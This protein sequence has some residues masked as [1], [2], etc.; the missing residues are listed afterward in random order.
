VYGDLLRTY[1][2]S[3]SSGKLF[4]PDMTPRGI[5]EYTLGYSKQ[6]PNGWT[7][8]FNSRYRKAGHFWEDTNNNARSRYGDTANIEGNSGEGPTDTSD[9]IPE[10]NDYRDQIGS[11]SSYVIAELDGAFTKYYEAGFDLEKRTADYYIKGSYTWSHYYGNFDQDNTTATNDANVFIGSSYI[12]DGAGRQIWDFKYGNLHG[13]RRHMLKVFGNYNLKWNGTV[14]VLAFFQSGQPWETWNVDTYRNWTG[15]SS[16][17]YRFS[18]PAGT[19][20][21]D[22]HYQ[23]DV[24][25]TQKFTFSNRYDLKLKLDIYNLTDNQTGYNINPYETS[26]TYGDPRS[27]FSPRRYRFAASFS[28]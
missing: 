18:E 6:L 19:H 12:A 26:S 9:Y 8:K 21:S 7:G 14:G 11:G 22:S 25:Y 4:V 3:S 20:T 24:S 23:V 13:D 10:L 1:D 16:S 28:F 2:R 15:S 17:T 27:Y 5:D